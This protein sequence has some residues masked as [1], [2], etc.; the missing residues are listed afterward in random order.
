MST[1]AQATRPKQQ[2]K[3]LRRDMFPPFIISTPDTCTLALIFQSVKT[4]D[5]YVT[6]LEVAASR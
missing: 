6:A 5:A 2:G 3:R 1:E 4:A